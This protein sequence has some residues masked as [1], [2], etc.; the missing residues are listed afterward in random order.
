MENQML[1]FGNNSDKCKTC[2]PFKGFKFIGI[3]AA[4]SI[5]GLFAV[6]FVETPPSVQLLLDTKH[7]RDTN[8][9][10]KQLDIMQQEVLSIKKNILIIKQTVEKNAHNGE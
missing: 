8:I 3:I 5:I 2:I 1:N 9:I 4:G 6:Q 10:I 7:D